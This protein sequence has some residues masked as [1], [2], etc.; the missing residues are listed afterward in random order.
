MTMKT[1]II[2]LLPFFLFACL[3]TE[4]S[5]TT[6][7]ADVT[8]IKDDTSEDSN[9]SI[10]DTNEDDANEDDASIDYCAIINDS[11]NP[12]GALEVPPPAVNSSCDCRVEFMW[13]SDNEYVYT[14]TTLP[15]PGLDCDWYQCRCH[16]MGYWECMW[17]YIGD[18]SGEPNEYVNDCFLDEED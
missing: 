6:D 14:E 2:S 3:S 16:S 1:F 17:L 4:D 12:Y 8:N 11:E 7:V 13:P 9:N 15:K 10:N 5:E 18:T